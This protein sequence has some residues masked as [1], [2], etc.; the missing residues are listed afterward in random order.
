MGQKGFWDAE[1]RLT[2][3]GRK[4]PTLKRLSATIEWERFRPLLESAFKKERKSS[5]GRKRI[6][7]IILFKMLVL[8]QL[9]NLSDEE[10]EF[11]V[12]DRR[13]FEKFVGLGVMDSIPDATTV[14]LFREQ[15]RQAEINEELF[16]MFNQYLSAQG[17]KAR[18]GQ[19]IDATL[20][21]VPKQRNRREENEEIKQGKVPQQWQANPNQLRQKDLDARWVKKNGVSHY[22]YKNSI[23]IDETYGL[24]RRHVV[25]PANIHDSQMLP[26]LLDG[27]NGESMV[28]ADSA[29]QSRMVDSFLKDAGYESKIQEKGSRQHPL[30]DAAKERNRERSK[31]RSR[32]EHVFAQMEMAMGGKLT[33][34]IGLARVKA[35]WCLRN[36]VFNFL[37]F[38]QH[39]YGLVSPPLI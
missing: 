22:G 37:R 18:G 33:R 7:V 31:T 28:W 19:I 16:H 13:S 24:I 14:A 23:S 27:E 20:V 32:V 15:L 10:L 35:W 26:A 11:Q 9:F 3:L 36:L 12:N 25:T 34:C 6:D 39:E 1:E 8:Q 21:P 29:Y 5:A 17:L 30:S 4:K 38:M 2:K